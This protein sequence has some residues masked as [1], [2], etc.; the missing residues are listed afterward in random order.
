MQLTHLNSILTPCTHITYIKCICTHQLQN[1]CMVVFS[2]ATLSFL[3]ARNIEKLGLAHKASMVVYP[4]MC[5]ST[6]WALYKTTDSQL[7][8][9]LGSLIHGIQQKWWNQMYNIIVTQSIRSSRQKKVIVIRLLQM[10]Q[11]FDVIT[12]K[13]SLMHE[14]V[15]ANWWCLK[16]CTLH[17][18]SS[19][20]FCMSES[21]ITK[22]SNNENSFIAVVYMVACATEKDW[23]RADMLP[24]LQ[25]QIPCVL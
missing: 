11:W 3:S 22:I 25:C 16:T 8:T 14:N 13:L 4:C 23:L 18:S 6:N 12:K 24:Y 19:L 1:Y 17:H 20:Q 5:K 21:A 10:S 2:H 7:M 15:H 9:G